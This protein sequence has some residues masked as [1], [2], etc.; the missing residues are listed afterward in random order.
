MG[1]TWSVTATCLKGGWTLIGPHWSVQ[2]E[3]YTNTVTDPHTRLVLL[4]S[5][6]PAWLDSI[7][8]GCKMTSAIITFVLTSHHDSLSSDY[9]LASPKII[10]YEGA[11]V[12][13]YS[14]SEEVYCTP[15][16][17]FTQRSP[18]PDSS[19]MKSQS[20]NQPPFGSTQMKEL[21]QY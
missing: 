6:L 15:P 17:L 20:D 2:L 13:T 10:Q 11:L 14:R 7:H 19:G 9:A 3:Q 21:V 1:K 8:R 16:C 12:P 18:I 5:V 4:H